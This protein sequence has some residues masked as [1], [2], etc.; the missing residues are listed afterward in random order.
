MKFALEKRKRG[1]KKKTNTLKQFSVLIVSRPTIISLIKYQIKHYTTIKSD[2]SPPYALNLW[3]SN[4]QP[5]I[6]LN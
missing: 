1:S 3:L 4:Y 2:F 6:L 5:Y